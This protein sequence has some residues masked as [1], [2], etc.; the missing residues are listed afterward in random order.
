MKLRRIVLTLI[1]IG[2]AVLAYVV[3]S[4]CLSDTKIAFVNY[5]SITLGQISKASKGTD[6]KLAMLDP[7][8]FDKLSDYDLVMING[9]GLRIT[10]EQRNLLL[11]K[12]E[13]GLP[14]LTTMA[15]NPAN[16]IVSVDS[17]SEKIIKK[18]LSAGG[19]ANYHN[20]LVYI[21]RNI[22]GK[23]ID[24]SAP[25]APKMRTY[26]QFYHIDPANP[27]EEDLEFDNLADYE[28]FLTD[29]NLYKKNAPRII[30]TG[31]MGDATSLVDSLEKSGNVV[32]P[33]RDMKALVRGHQIDTINPAAVINMAHGRL[34]DFA[35]DYLKTANIPLFSPL[36]V[37]SLVSEWEADKM[38]M[39]GGFMSQSVVMPEIDGAIRP[40]VLFGHYPDGEGLEKLTAIPGRLTEF[41]NTVN[42]HISLKTIPNSEKKLVIYYYKGPGNTALTASGM[43]VVPSLFN[44]LT[45]LKNAGYN[46]KNLPA[47]PAE[48]GVLL[49][50]Q[51]AVY[52]AYASGAKEKFLKEGNPLLI[53]ADEYSSWT[54]KVLKPEQIN[55]INALDGTF[56]GSY[57]S[58]ED[59]KLALPHI[60]FGNVVLM[61]QLAAGAGNDDFAIVHGTDAA[62]PHAYV[63][64][65]LWARFGFKADAIMH[66]GTHGSLEFTPR[67]QVALSNNDWSDRLVSEMPHI[68]IYSI[69]NIGEAIIAKR[70]AYATLVSHLTPP[71]IESNVTG[72]YKSLTEA[73]RD[74]NENSTDAAS[75]KV[76]RL[77]VKLGIH[78]ELRLDS[79][80]NVP[81]TEKEISRISSFAEELTNEKVTGKLYT[82]GERYSESEIH[83]MS[84]SLKDSARAEYEENLR[85][86]P[87]LELE[88]ILNALNGGYTAP[89]PGGDA[90]ANPNSVPSGRNMYSVNPEATPSE[91]AWREGVK[92]AQ[93]TIDMYR[94]RHNDSIPRKVSYTLWSGEFVETQGATI[95][96]IFYML[97]VEPIRDYFGRVT[98]IRLIP[99]EK[100]GRPRIDV[101]VQTSGQL[102][103]LAASRLFLITR[104]V[105]M[106]SKADDKYEN[107]VAQGV[108]DAEKAL[109]D[110]G[111]SPKDARHAST[112]RVFGGVNGGYGT[113]ITGMVQ[114][115][116]GWDDKKQIAEVYMSNMGAFYGSQEEWENVQNLAF[117][118]AL[119]NT[120][121]VIQPRQSNTWGALSLDHVYEFMGGLNLA[122]KT[123]TGKE[124]DAYFSDYR[125]H[126]KMRMQELKEAIGVESRTT[127]FNPAYIQEKMKGEASSAAGFSEI[128]KNI[129]GWDVMRDEAIDQETWNEVY[130]VYVKDK[131]N[132]GTQNFFEG[133]SPAALQEM[134]ATMLEAARRD[135]WHASEEQINTLANL[136]TELI[137]KY[138]PACSESVCNNAR[139][140]QFISSHTDKAK[141]E[142][143]NQQIRDVR[144]AAA[145]G[146]DKSVVM[147]KD[148]TSADSQKEMILNGA[149]IGIIFLAIVAG[150]IYVVR[151]R[152]KDNEE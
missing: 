69:G 47:T 19:R 111:L 73:V 43:E 127:I 140:R 40:Y 76:K 89:S 6:V 106:A 144:Q 10:E 151:R 142:K 1:I 105:E 52:N 71:F 36:N 98:D 136:H 53:T 118:A 149:I 77:T 75:L 138:E 119:T 91:D 86:S 148:E 65:Y 112:F 14:V 123:V 54:N 29:K 95:A 64:E 116:D 131:F 24:S 21:R 15:T 4:M 99:S 39:V 114:S 92:L 67:K 44:L 109:V 27:E 5:Q 141:A 11:E 50:K 100:L 133:K 45:A 3:W 145:S 22:D 78:R 110:K 32:Y 97:G 124:P 108:V 63:A 107:Y 33:V 18:Y 143:Y 87:R 13:K 115:G 125:N 129:Y 41:V 132:L 30:V 150:L 93:N 46:V 134:T 139:L 23:T 135:M 9:M 70:R 42:R 104:A 8:E 120:D 74:Y 25:D 96:Q 38:G 117:E 17:I 56:P 94:E 35:V 20:M 66:F 128:V 122:V 49:Q 130:D 146:G 37:N 28:K 58:T 152:R 121:A 16:D 2:L 68:Y 102:R 57:I 12:V 48:L 59:G 26:G 113:G 7:E 81:Y 147:K 55:D 31:V 126:N 88:A 82:L 85:N 79:N 101:V 51:G 34:G 103:D 80:L 62:P 72:T 61:P 60:D 84:K 83:T 90:L 137:E